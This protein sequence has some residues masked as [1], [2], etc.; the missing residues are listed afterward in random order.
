[1]CHTQLDSSLLSI[2]GS[3]T[4]LSRNDST[5]HGLHLNISGKEKM[6]ELIR[7]KQKKK[8]HGRKEETPI[9]LKWEEN[10]KIL[11]RKRLKK[12]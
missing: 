9:T 6:A 7:G 3:V 12:N 4:N 5:L 11:L 1:M 2:T 10:Q 8:T